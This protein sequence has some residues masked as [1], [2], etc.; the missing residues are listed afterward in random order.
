M[1]KQRYPNRV[2]ICLRAWVALN[3]PL[4]SE[5]RNVVCKKSDAMRGN[6]MPNAG[7]Q[8]VLG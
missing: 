6:Q 2:N 8:P 7:I 1:V 3:A 5:N 4:F